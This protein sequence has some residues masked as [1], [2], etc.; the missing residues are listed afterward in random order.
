MSQSVVGTVNLAVRSV[1]IDSIFT[2][3]IDGVTYSVVKNVNGTIMGINNVGD[4]YWTNNAPGAW[5]VCL[6]NSDSTLLIYKYG[7]VAFSMNFPN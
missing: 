6:P 4:I 5:E 1:V 3:V 7:V 2:T